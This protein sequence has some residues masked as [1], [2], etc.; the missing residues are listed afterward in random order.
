M[1]VDAELKESVV[2]FCCVV[3]ISVLCTSVDVDDF[4]EVW[5]LEAVE[6]DNVVNP[7]LL[8]ETTSVVAEIWLVGRFVCDGSEFDGTPVWFGVVGK[9]EVGVV[10]TTA[11]DIGVTSGDVDVFADVPDVPVAGSDTV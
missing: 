1:E 3:T 2:S 11:E 6:I 5:S 4:V 8:V 7:E 10:D 9:G